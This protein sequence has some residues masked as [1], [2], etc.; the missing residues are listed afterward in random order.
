MPLHLLGENNF[1]P[2]VSVE[3]IKL[4]FTDPLTLSREIGPTIPQA[5]GKVLDGFCMENLTIRIFKLKR[6]CYRVLSFHVSL[7]DSRDIVQLY[8]YLPLLLDR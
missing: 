2:V 1:N 5:H 7:I 8:E 6:L 4:I 3:W